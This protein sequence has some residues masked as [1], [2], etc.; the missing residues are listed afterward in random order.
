MISSPPKQVAIIGA[1]LTGLTLAISL[2]RQGVQCRIYE[3][4]QPTV[5]TSGAL[6]LSPNALRILDTLGLYER[7]YKKGYNFETIDYKNHNQVTTDYYY[8]GSEKRYGYKALR[9]YRQVLLTELRAEIKN[10]EIPVTYGVKFSHIISEDDNGVNFAFIDG[11]HATA[12]ILAGTDGIHST[13]RKYI[14]PEVVPKY[15]GSVAITC[16]LPRNV[17]EYPSNI[18]AKDYPMPVAIHDKN[19]AFVMAPQN[20]EGSEVLAGT[21]RA[22]P[23]Q[24]RAGWDALLADREGLLELFRQGYESWPKIVQ[25]A[26]DNV[27]LNTLAIWP[28]YIVPKLESWFS[29][30]KRV[31]ILGDAAHAIP[32]TAGQGASQ[33]FEDAFTLAALLPR[34]TPKLPL[35]KALTEW[36]EMR[37][38][39]IDKVIK[40]TLQLNNARLPEAEREKLA[41]AGT[42][43]WQSGDQGELGWLYNADVEKE[44][45]ASVKADTKNSH[46]CQVEWLTSK[47]STTKPGDL[48][49]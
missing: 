41:A 47:M 40:L 26:L 30:N 28:Y 49:P 7:L 22:Y 1:G 3:L 19:G 5:A 31:I 48:A 24:D 21:Q 17:L 16:A 2:H 39:R 37:Q 32:P 34:I 43:V 46:T 20:I 9:I 8:L 44:V 6:M 36:K 38:R 14:A 27:L 33:G 15:S 13:V 10:L 29:A 4:R 35:D 18:S 11:T 45:L 12:D 42:E 25:S 23:E